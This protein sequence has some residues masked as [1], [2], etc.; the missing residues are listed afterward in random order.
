MRR[1]TSAGVLILVACGSPAQPE[2]LVVGDV[3][4]EIPS[5]EVLSITREPH[6]FARISPEGRPFHLVLDSRSQGQQDARGAPAIHS[7]NDGS[8][9]GIS[10]HR[11]GQHFVVC[12][13]AVNPNGGCGMAIDHAGHRWH[14]LFPDSRLSEAD[15]FAAEAR[16]SL[17]RYQVG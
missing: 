15:A 9:P 12:R 3:T 11:V 14:L 7:L 10:Y 17:G 4:Y 16:A 2:Q 13:R 8:S 6:L 5:R 1:L